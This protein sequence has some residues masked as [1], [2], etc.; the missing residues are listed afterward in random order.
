MFAGRFP[1]AIKKLI[2][3]FTLKATNNMYFSVG[4]GLIGIINFTWIFANILIT[5]LSELDSNKS[6]LFQ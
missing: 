5:V 1:H 6:F 3:Q 2:L 4:I